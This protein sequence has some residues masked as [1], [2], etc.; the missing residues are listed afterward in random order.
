MKKYILSACSFFIATQIL[1]SHI[2]HT[3]GSVKNTVGEKSPKVPIYHSINSNTPSGDIYI[4]TGKISGYN[5][6]T[7]MHTSRKKTRKGTFN[8]STIKKSAIEDDALHPLLKNPIP[9]ATRN[10]IGFIRN[11]H[12]SPQTYATTPKNIP[13]YEYTGSIS[14]I[15]AE[16]IAQ[17]AP[18]KSIQKETPHN[19]NQANNRK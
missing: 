3:E 15:S 4:R 8:I 12:Y 5:A 14:S 7:F 10:I 6:G 1:A 2:Y 16:K 13:L 18:A 17:K 11:P 19:T 9:G